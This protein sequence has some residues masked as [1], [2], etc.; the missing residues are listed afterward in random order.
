MS[1]T[2]F[3]LVVAFFAGLAWYLASCGDGIGVRGKSLD[4]DLCRDVCRKILIFQESIG[5]IIGKLDWLPCVASAAPGANT[6]STSEDT[7]AQ[8]SAASSTIEDTSHKYSNHGSAIG[9]HD[10]CIV[11][12]LHTF[13]GHGG[14]LFSV[15]EDSEVRT[16]GPDKNKSAV[17]VDLAAINN[18]RHA[19]SITSSRRLLHVQSKP[20]HPLQKQRE[21]KSPYSSSWKNPDVEYLMHCSSNL[22][23]DLLTSWNVPNDS[24]CHWHGNVQRL[25]RLVES[26]RS[27]HSCSEVWPTKEP[28]WQC[29]SCDGLQ[30]EGSS[31][32]ACWICCNQ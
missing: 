23:L 18:I 1:E 6:C 3:M 17:H 20:Q 15:P 14:Q 31:P 8:W 10:G 16:F 19:P 21:L 13:S 29:E 22:M 9:M 4:V 11:R 24:C 7:A 26:M 12:E 5:R 32:R 27:W 25:S 28:G 30:F 2:V